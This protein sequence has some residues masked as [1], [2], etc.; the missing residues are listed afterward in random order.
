M[1]YAQ[2][3][4]WFDRIARSRVPV[5]VWLI[6]FWFVLIFPAILLRG[7]HFEEGTVT[8]L[9]RGAIE[10]GHWLVPH[11]YGFRFQE[12]PV[13]MSWVL[14]VIGLPFG[15]LSPAAARIPA[16]LSL[17]GGGALIFYLVRQ[18][19]SH[20]AALFGAVCF[21][22]AP[23]LLRKLITAEP[24][25]M[26]SVLLFA[27]MVVWWDGHKTGHVSLMRWIAAGLLVG[28]AALT[29]GP[30]PAA[31]F[32][33]GLGAFLLIK[34][35]W[36]E[37]P[38]FVAANAIAGVL[39]L[40]WYVAIYQPGDLDRWAGHSRLAAASDPVSYLVGVAAFAGKF[41]VDAIPAII[42]AVPFI[43]ALARQRLLM[44]DDLVLALLCYALVCTMALM[45]WPGAHPRYAMPAFFALAAIAGLG[46]EW[47]RGRSTIAF[48]TVVVV[49]CGLAIYPV[50]AGWIVTPLMPGSSQ[51]SRHD[52][53]AVMAQMAE[54]PGTLYSTPLTYKNNALVYV[55]KPIRSMP[56]EDLARLKSPEW[57]LLREDEAQRLRTLRPDLTVTQRTSLPPGYPAGNDFDLYRAAAK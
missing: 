49:A 26:L 56:V 44:R 30:Q 31:Y 17:L 15:G 40:A 23:A 53:Q 5:W 37:M 50:V 9:A 25:V 13:L 24:D 2:P 41:A 6:A 1:K 33:L 43:A 16:V 28:A 29:K 38:G 46:Y 32:T 20:A 21:L 18:R 34:R 10:D 12:R 35:E 45:L 39:V 51:R 52:A 19:C 4:D 54:R 11:L 48:N 57:L 3:F 55:P 47:L 27:A 14:A 8:A 22:V 42:V 7:T 36:K